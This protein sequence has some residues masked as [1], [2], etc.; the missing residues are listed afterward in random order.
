MCARSRAC[1]C[2]GGGRRGGGGGWQSAVLALLMNRGAS[3]CCCPPTTQSLVGYA[4]CLEEL[5]RP[6]AGTDASPAL[7]AVSGKAWIGVV[8]R[9]MVG[10]M[11]HL[12]ALSA[13]PN[14]GLRHRRCAACRPSFR[15]FRFF[16]YTARTD[17]GL[18]RPPPA[19]PPHPTLGQELDQLPGWGLW[20][21][22]VGGDGGPVSM[23]DGCRCGCGAG[24]PHAPLSL[25]P[26]H[27][28]ACAASSRHAVP[29]AARRKGWS[30]RPGFPR[31]F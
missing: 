27:P 13:P 26:H 12:K 21:D 19:L 16:I 17:T 25:Y 14:K 2:G 30:T 24:D 22:P 8:G 9:M 3:L 10:A 4:H 15:H 6:I 7:G 31:R 28:D 1:V 18:L 23:D 11:R 5:A 20:Q 29:R